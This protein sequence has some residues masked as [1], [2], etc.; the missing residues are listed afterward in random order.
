MIA[1]VADVGRDPCK[2]QQKQNKQNKSVVCETQAIEKYEEPSSSHVDLVVKPPEI[3]SVVFNG[4]CLLTCLLT[5]YVLLLFSYFLKRRVALTPTPTPRRA[6]LAIR[7][8]GGG[9]G[10]EGGRGRGIVDRKSAGQQCSAHR[11]EE[12]TREARL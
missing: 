7:Q 3:Q 12:I 10:G 6:T 9:G 8:G 11:D 2:S 5:S 4:G 1:G